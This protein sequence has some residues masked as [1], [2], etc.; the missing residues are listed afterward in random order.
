MGD[1]LHGK[2]CGH[3]WSALL[4]KVS[5]MLLSSKSSSPPLLFSVSPLLQPRS[6]SVGSSSVF[7]YS[8]SVLRLSLLPSGFL[9]LREKGPDIT[10]SVPQASGSEPCEQ[11]S[12]SAGEPPKEYCTSL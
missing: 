4:P 1:A 5:H 10:H 9:S 2:W 7:S 12:E 3:N 11:S 8:P 6:V